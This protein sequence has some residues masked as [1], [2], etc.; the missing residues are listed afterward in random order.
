[1]TAGPRHVSIGYLRHLSEIAPTKEDQWHF[2]AVA[3]EIERLRAENAELQSRLDTA[4]DKVIDM[5][6]KRLR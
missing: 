5:L 2:A 6:R 3:D 1:M 4:V